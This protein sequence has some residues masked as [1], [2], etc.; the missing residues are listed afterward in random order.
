MS[1]HDYGP[2]A[3]TAWEWRRSLGVID[4]IRMEIDYHTKELADAKRRFDE[5]VERCNRLGRDLKT[6]VR[7]AANKG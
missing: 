2:L 4:S 5:A 6:L 7:D 3:D 1:D